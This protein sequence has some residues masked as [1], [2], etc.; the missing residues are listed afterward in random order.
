MSIEVAYLSSSVFTYF[1]D[2]GLSTF[3]AGTSFALACSWETLFFS[4]VSEEGAEATEFISARR[5]SII[6]STSSQSS[7]SFSARFF[8]TAFS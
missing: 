6:I 1:L 2:I 4:I 8:K 7:P 3:K 5:A